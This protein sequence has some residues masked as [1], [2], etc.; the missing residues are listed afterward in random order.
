MSILLKIFLPIASLVLA[1]ALFLVVYFPQVQTERATTALQTKA[2]TVNNLVAHTLTPRV[3][4]ALNLKMD[5][6]SL[7][8]EVNPLFISASQDKDLVFI[9]LYDSEG[10]R[11]KACADEESEDQDPFGAGPA[12]NCSQWRELDLSHIPDEK[13]KIE[14]PRL[15]ESALVSGDA[16]TL[17]DDPSMLRVLTPVKI[18]DQIKGWLLSGFSLKSVEQERKQ[19]LTLAIIAASV[20]LLIGLSISFVLGLY[21]NRRMQ[22]IAAVAHRFAAGDLTQSKIEEKSPD[23]VGQLADSINQM[24]ASQ[25]QLVSSIAATARQI[26]T[27][28]GDIL[29]NSH[30]HQKGAVA[31]S[32]AV[33]QT[34]HAMGNLRDASHTIVENSQGV[35][36]N[37]ELTLQ[38]NRQIGRSIGEL[39]N[40]S[41]RIA[42]ILEVI[43]DIANK[44]DLLALNAALEGTKAG[45]AGRGFSLVAQQMQR[46]AENVMQSAVN[47]K[48]LTSDIKDATGASV[49]AS[50]EALRLAADTTE[51][52]RVINELAQQQQ[53]GTE[54]ATNAINDIH[55]VAQQVVDGNRLTIEVTTQ[56]VDHSKVLQTLIKDFRTDSTAKT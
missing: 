26:D 40:H 16:R 23:A 43:K 42:D 50:E 31:Q 5:P 7:P 36:D 45:E 37:A 18:E 53:L 56:L 3:D 13:T 6:S 52:A 17:T 38:N 33:E 29:S 48:E 34:R 46:L 24:L 20:T 25:Q 41:Q 12:A 15:L 54:Q 19:S 11:F 27:T 28:A 22:R 8:S 51:S 21:F 32:D 14:T 39:S 49:L 1:I 47:I 9:A 55:N 4:V 35:L 44:S 10:R 2:E 30:A